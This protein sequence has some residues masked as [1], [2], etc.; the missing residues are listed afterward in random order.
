[1]KPYRADAVVPHPNPAAIGAAAAQ[2]RWPRRPPLRVEGALGLRR[3]WVPGPPAF[4]AR[5]W[6][7][8]RSENDGGKGFGRQAGLARSFGIM[9]GSDH[10]RCFRQR[11]G[12]LRA[13]RHAIF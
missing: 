2:P 7:G 9:R 5:A 13:R 6:F 4:A 8:A 10:A 11:R 12:V 3:D 1:M